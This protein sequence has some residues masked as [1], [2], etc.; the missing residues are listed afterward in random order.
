[1]TKT[2]LSTLCYR[3]NGISNLGT[4]IEKY[5]IEENSVTV[6]L[7]FV[8]LYGYNVIFHPLITDES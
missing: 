5:L 6:T 2:L 4:I 8:K 7:S 3:R 1:M